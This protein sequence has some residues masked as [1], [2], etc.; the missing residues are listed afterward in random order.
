[1]QRSSNLLTALA[2]PLFFLCVAAYVWVSSKAMP[3][4][5][6]SHFDAIG[7]ANGRMRR[8]VYGLFMSGLILV[9]P[10]LVVYLPNAIMRRSVNRIN[11]PNRQYWLAPERREQTI[12]RLCRGSVGFGYLLIGFLAYAHHLVVIANQSEPPTLPST[13]FVAGLVFFVGASLVWGWLYIRPFLQVPP[14]E[15]GR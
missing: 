15:F 11:L 14:R 9:L 8:E 10:L 13:W 12:A 2:F 3:E 4:V 6:A 1:M 7:Q 5:I